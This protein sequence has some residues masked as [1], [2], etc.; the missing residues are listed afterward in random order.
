MEV[1]EHVDLTS[2]TSY[3]RYGQSLPVDFDA[4][5]Y[6]AVISIDQGKIRSF[7]QELRLSGSLREDGIRW[8]IGGNYQNDRIDE[9]LVQDPIINSVTQIGPV[10]FDSFFIDN[11]QKVETKAVFG[12]LDVKITPTLTAQGS[13][14][15]TKQNRDFAG[16]TRDSGNG[17]T[18]AALSFLSTVLTG[19]VQNYAPGSCITLSPGTFLA[20]PIIR[21]Q[22]DEDNVSWR[23]SLNWT[24][25][26]NALFYGNVTKG[27]KSGSFPTIPALFTPSL[28][29]VPQES[30]L[31]YEVGT[32]LSLLS[33]AL[34]IDGALFYYD[35]RDKQLSGFVVVPPLGPVPSL[36][37]IP[38]TTV[39]GAEVSATLRPFSGLTLTGSATYVKTR[40]DRNPINPTGTFGNTADLVGQRFPN[41]PAWQTAAD[42]LYRFPVGSGTDA[43]FGASATYRSS[44]SGILLTEDPAVAARE[45]PLKI[46]AYTLIDLRAGL[47]LEG[48]KLR[49][50]AWGR[51]V[52][53][54]FYLIGSA[55][56]SD[57]VARFT[58][59]PATYGLS[60]Y[61]R[62]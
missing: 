18:A 40:I 8:M 6:P 9:R 62:Y 55:R 42:A 33:R 54:R 41:T 15:Y 30:V 28:T 51:N 46:P 14:R 26:R 58:G 57:T 13:L 1:A 3:Q 32:K 52:T 35:Y 21:G 2:L 34:Q 48:G 17:Q 44:T 36:V 49:V 11:L 29:P 19:K 25:S 50:E 38:K 27:Y 31:A 12:S 59:M 37:S 10:S 43:Y 39:K 61:L 20:P 53:N 23:G 60:L 24:P 4:T 16:C 45:A 5:T 47:E 7:S 56:A 22:L